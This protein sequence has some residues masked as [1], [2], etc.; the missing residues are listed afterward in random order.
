LGKGREGGISRTKSSISWS[1][2]GV[3]TCP[4]ELKHQKRTSRGKARTPAFDEGEKKI[5]KKR[6]PQTNL[7]LHK[8]R[9]RRAKRDAGLKPGREGEGRYAQRKK[10]GGGTPGRGGQILVSP[11][12]KKNL[13]RP[14][15]KEKKGERFKRGV[16]L[17]VTHRQAFTL[18]L[19][20]GG[21]PPSPPKKML[22]IQKE[23]GFCLLNQSVRGKK[24]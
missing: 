17:R 21:T 22:G 1:G 16:R 14:E 11:D 8:G 3:P 12:H 9:R 13:S 20:G 7:L 5:K 6:G 24:T 15:K 18:T 4:V 10:R 2:V 19:P 23:K